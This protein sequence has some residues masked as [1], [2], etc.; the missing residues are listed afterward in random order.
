MAN[1]LDSSF[2]TAQLNYSRSIFFDAKVIKMSDG[3][4][5]SAQDFVTH[6]LSGTSGEPVNGREQRTPVT[7]DTDWFMSQGPGKNVSL[8]SFTGVQSLYFSGAAQKV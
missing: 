1:S 4:F 2:L 5:W 3:S 8:A 6:Y 7:V